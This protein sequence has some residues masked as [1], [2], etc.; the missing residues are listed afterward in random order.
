[1]G[2]TE[3]KEVKKQVDSD[4][5]TVVHVHLPTFAIVLF[6]IVIALITVAIVTYCVK[7][8]RQ[9]TPEAP[10]PVTN[11][12]TVPQPHIPTLFPPQPPPF[13]PFWS[14]LPQLPQLPQQM[15]QMLPALPT[16]RADNFQ[17]E[18]DPSLIRNLF[19]RRRPRHYHQREP[20]PEPSAQMQRQHN[21]VLM[22]DVESEDGFP[23]T[24]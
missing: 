2:S 10:A 7:K 3:T 20:I 18:V 16:P 22:E 6:L 1:M 24:P 21:E 19:G 13:N 23:I 4:N 12:Y 17:L 14:Q 11:P 9:V 5:F 15:Q 8:K